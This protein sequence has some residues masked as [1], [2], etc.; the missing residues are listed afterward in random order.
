MSAVIFASG[1]FT[2][3]DNQGGPAFGIFAAL[4]GGE[5]IQLPAYTED[6]TQ[7]R[8]GNPGLSAGWPVPSTL[9]TSDSRHRARV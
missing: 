4:P 5:V 8:T 9:S 3:A 1:F 7:A 6:D 2:P